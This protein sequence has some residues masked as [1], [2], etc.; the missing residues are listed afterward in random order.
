MTS[1]PTQGNG[2]SLRTFQTLTYAMQSFTADQLN[3]QQQQ[4]QQA[5]NTQGLCPSFRLGFSAMRSILLQTRCLFLFQTFLEE[6][7]W[8]C[9]DP[10]FYLFSG[11]TVRT[12]GVTFQQGL[13]FTYLTAFLYSFVQHCSEAECAENNSVQLFLHWLEFWQELAKRSQFSATSH[14]KAPAT[15]FAA[16]STAHRCWP[17]CAALWLRLHRFA[18]CLSLFLAGAHSAWSLDC[19]TEHSRA[20]RTAG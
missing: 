20:K 11:W 1:F 3:T 5:V 18:T 13:S 6:H 2:V 7:I 9:H 10:G 17:F 14:P 12:L 19:T 8:L 4:Q 15:G 16:L